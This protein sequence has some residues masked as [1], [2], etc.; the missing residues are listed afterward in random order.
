VCWNSNDEDLKGQGLRH[1]FN[2]VKDRLGETVH[3]REL[4]L[5]DYPYQQLMDLFVKEDYDGW[6]LLEARSK[7]ADRIAALHEQK[8]VFDQMV[9][10]AQAKL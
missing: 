10:N 2:L 5:G 6:I 9:A 4:N 3:V 8:Q 1:N 7:P